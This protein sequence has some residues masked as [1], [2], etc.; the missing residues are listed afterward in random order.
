MKYDDRFNLQRDGTI[1]VIIDLQTQLMSAM[2]KRVITLIEKNNNLLISSLKIFDIPTIVTEQYPKGLG[3]TC[4]SVRNNL[5]DRYN[6]IDKVVFSCWREPSFQEKMKA[7]QPVTVIISGIETHVCVLQTALDLIGEGYSV[8][9]PVDA[10]C[11][12]FK[13]DWKSALNS[14]SSAGAV[15]TSVETIVFQLLEKAGTPE[16]KAISPLIKE[17]GNDIPQ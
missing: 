2:E 14:L 17:R 5:G 3:N 10:T 8:H 11:S 9:I 6:P 12:R 15:I 1:C 7:F 13:S 16:F 4:E